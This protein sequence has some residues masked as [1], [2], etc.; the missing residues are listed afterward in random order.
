MNENQNLRTLALDVE[1]GKFKALDLV[2]MFNME[3]APDLTIENVGFSIGNVSGKVRVHYADEQRMAVSS[4]ETSDLKN[5][6]VSGVDAVAGGIQV[7]GLLDAPPKIDMLFKADIVTDGVN[8]IGSYSRTEIEAG[9]I[10]DYSVVLSSGYSFGFRLNLANDPAIEELSKGSI[11]GPISYADNDLSVSSYNM[12]GNVALILDR[13]GETL[14]DANGVLTAAGICD[15]KT[16]DYILLNKDFTY[17]SLSEAMESGAMITLRV[18]VSGTP[19]L[20]YC[21]LPVRSLSSSGMKIAFLSAVG[22]VVFKDNG[23][24]EFVENE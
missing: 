17:S 21:S 19:M 10:Y 24:W 14:S 18:S 22:R 7:N 16:K 12:D 20:V 8:P 9:V 5:I 15:F 11:S 3:V 23:D 6:A 13:E 1:T 4:Y 2:R